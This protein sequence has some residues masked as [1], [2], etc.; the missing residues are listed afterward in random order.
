MQTGRGQKQEGRQCPERL[1]LT[2]EVSTTDGLRVGVPLHA[3][4]NLLPA[5]RTRLAKVSRLNARYGRDTEPVFQ[6]FRIPLAAFSS[7]EPRFEPRNL[8]GIRFLVGGGSSGGVILDNVGFME[9]W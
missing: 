1:Q 5:L 6:A 2:V 9:E 8:N 7:L 4:G 3:Y